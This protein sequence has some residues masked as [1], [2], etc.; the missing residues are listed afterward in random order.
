MGREEG[1]QRFF[2]AAAFALVACCAVMSAFFFWLTP[3]A[4]VCF[5]EACFCADFGDLS[6]MWGFP[7]LSGLTFGMFVSP[8]AYATYVHLVPDSEQ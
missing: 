3:S 2:P 6:P 7:W 8:T 4:F 1:G 5:C